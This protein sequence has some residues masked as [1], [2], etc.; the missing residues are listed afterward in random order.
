MSFD[1]FFVAATNE[2]QAMEIVQNDCEP[3]AATPAEQARM[4]AIIAALIEAYP[5]AKSG[6]AS[7]GL[8][9][10][11]WV[12]GGDLPPIDIGPK[13]AFFSGHPDLTDIESA[14]RLF[15]ELLAVFERQGYIGFDPQEGRIATSR[16]FSFRPESSAPAVAPRAA[17]GPTR[18]RKPWWKFW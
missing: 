4:R 11:A 10:G 18:S 14:D 17:A 9:D 1:F 16:S 12:E 15:R 8:E 5:G 3:R 13:C 6:E 2:T 7:G